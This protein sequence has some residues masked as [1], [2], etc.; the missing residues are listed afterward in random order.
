MVRIGIDNGADGGIV[1]LDGACAVVD[2]TIM[3]VLDVGVTRN[4]KRGT[5]RVL[6]MHS[7]LTMLTR[8]KGQDTDVYAVLEH[9]QTFPGEG[10]STAFNA[11]RGY[12]AMEMALVAAGIPYDIVRPRI[13]QQTALKGIEGADTKARAIL[14]CQRA[15]PALELVWGRRRKPHTGLADAACMA[16]YALT[17]RP[18]V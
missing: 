2:S 13:W 17:I 12:G 16:L 9:A 7:V 4:G 10:R 8:L 6:D 5:K 1:A 18:G 11:G 15:V 3:P 14:R